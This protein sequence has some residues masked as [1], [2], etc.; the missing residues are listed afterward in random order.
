MLSF[1]FVSQD[2]QRGGG[3][4]L[5]VRGDGELRMR[6]DLRRLADLA[7]ARAHLEH[8]LA[9]LD[10][11]HRDSRDIELLA[12]GI[13]VGIEIGER[14]RAG[15]GSGRGRGDLLCLRGQRE[16]EA[17]GSESEKLVKTR[18]GGPPGLMSAG[19]IPCRVRARYVSIS[20]CFSG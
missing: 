12:G 5:R 19:T 16:G 6:V 20:P 13:H 14:N 3:K 9:V 2:R 10:D 1:F 4:R 11:R 8:D 17:R 15:V 7:H 18:H